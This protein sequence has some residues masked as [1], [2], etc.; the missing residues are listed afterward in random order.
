[1]LSGAGRGG[2]SSGLIDCQRRASMRW[3]CRHRRCSSGRVAARRTPLR[4][5]QLFPGRQRCGRRRACGRGGR[6]ALRHRRTAGSN[7]GHQQ[8]QGVQSGHDSLHRQVGIAQPQVQIGIFVVERAVVFHRGKHRCRR[9]A[10]QRA[11]AG[12]LQAYPQRHHQRACTGQPPAPAPRWRPWRRG[13]RGAAGPT[14]QAT[15]PAATA[16]A[17][18]QGVVGRQGAFHGWISDNPAAPAGRVPDGFYR[19]FA[20]AH[21]AGGGGPVQVLQHAQ[22]EG[23]ALA[24]GQAAQRVHQ[25]LVLLRCSCACAGSGPG[26]AQ[27]IR[28]LPRPGCRARTAGGSGAGA[29]RRSRAGAGCSRTAAPIR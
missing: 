26:S 4:F 5:T 8:G 21:G 22:G 13:E 20:A 27:S 16:H 7:W 29:A 18:A 23:L 19:A 6:G 25:L 24:G 1:M 28:R 10:R 15:A 14:L 9:R 12:E 17:A 2:R 3:R 11:M